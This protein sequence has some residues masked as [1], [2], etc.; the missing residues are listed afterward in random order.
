[1]T[2][3]EEIYAL[4]RI[5]TRFPWC[6]ACGRS[7]YERPLGYSGGV[8]TLERAHIVSSPRRKD[9]R[10]VVLLCSLCHR[11]QHG[12]RFT[13]PGAPPAVDLANMLWLK[14]RFDP[15]YYSR[16]WLARSS[17]RSLPRARRPAPELEAL[18]KSRRGG[19]PLG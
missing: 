16:A 19:Y 4:F 7:D 15:G 14:S 12:E 17:V 18:Y 8:W 2:D 10:A 9:R 11:L 6:W 3:P 5:E 13:L 1:M